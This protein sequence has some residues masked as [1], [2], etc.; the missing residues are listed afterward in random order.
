MT[1]MKCWCSLVSGKGGKG[2]AKG[3]ESQ[4]D[5]KGLFL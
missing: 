5:A 4:V 1:Q 2:D 3:R